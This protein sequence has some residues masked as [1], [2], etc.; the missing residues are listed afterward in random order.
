[1]SQ[2]LRIVPPTSD[3]YRDEAHLSSELTRVFD[4]CN[5]CRRCYNLCPSF[6]HLL[7]SLDERADFEAKNLTQEDTFKVVDLC[8]QC[9]LCYNHC[10]YTPPHE[11]ELDFPA[12]MLRSKVV[13][14]KERR[15]PI[16]KLMAAT[17]LVGKM[18]SMTAP[19]ANMG[20]KNPVGRQLLQVVAGIHK[21][22]LLPKF[23]WTT[24]TKWD[25]ANHPAPP[26]T[27]VDSVVLFY[28][29]IGNFFDPPMV[30]DTAKVL[31]HNDVVFEV[32]KQECCGMANLDIGDIE[33]ATKKAQANVDV[34]LPLVRAGKKIVVPSPSC[35]LMLKQEYPRLLGTAEAQEISANTYDVGQYLMWLRREGK[36]KQDFTEGFSGKKIGYH[37]PCHLRAQN[38][39]LTSRDLL[40]LIPGV[41]VTAIEQCSAHDGSWGMSKEFYEESM[42]MGGKLFRQMKEAEPDI[43]ATDCSFASLHLNQALGTVPMHPI[44]IVREAYGL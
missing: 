36:L 10:P 38:I 3:Q 14:R 6:P 19:L 7:D 8:Y 18:G 33:A 42:K 5:S 41:E 32:P 35:S 20:N 31:A 13:Q 24:F 16:K 37:A 17:N 15:G 40:S 27:P 43:V 21:D 11:W 4:I 22:A 1:M 34:L 25:K 39:G 12:L 9:Q 2:N 44:Q 28:T 26:A 30:I 23:H 29:C